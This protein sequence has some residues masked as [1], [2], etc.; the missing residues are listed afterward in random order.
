MFVVTKYFY[1]DKSKHV[2]VATSILLSRQQTC[3]VATKKERKILVA[4]P[5]NDSAEFWTISL[6]VQDEVQSC[7]GMDS[8]AGV[9][10]VLSLCTPPIQRRLMAPFAGFCEA[11]GDGLFVCVERWKGGG[12]GRERERETERQTETDR[13][14]QRERQ[15]QTDRQTDRDRDRARVS[16]SFTISSF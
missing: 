16:Y 9:I 4:A 2:F 5:A 13:E 1:C 6:L 8:S 14:R 12:G 11:G 7:S 15:R 3:F 10:T